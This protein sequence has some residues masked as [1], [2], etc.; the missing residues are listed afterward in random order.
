[1]TTHFSKW[2]AK[3]KIPKRELAIAFAEL[4]AGN[5]EANLG[6][7]LYKKRIHLEDQGK[8]G[9]ERTILCYKK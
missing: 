4:A 1:M 9:G 3:Q 7:N 5:F 2:A 6:G 8:G